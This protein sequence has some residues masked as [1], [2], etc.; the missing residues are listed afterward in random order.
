VRGVKKV[1]K[2]EDTIQKGEARKVRM[3][4]VISHV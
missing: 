1:V 2:K 3:F 4:F